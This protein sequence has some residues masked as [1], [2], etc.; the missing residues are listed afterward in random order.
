MTFARMSVRDKHLQKA[1]ECD[2]GFERSIRDVLYRPR[3]DMIG[4]PSLQEERPL[5]YAGECFV[6]M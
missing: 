6:Y 1:R 3:R 2:R 5:E 4:Q